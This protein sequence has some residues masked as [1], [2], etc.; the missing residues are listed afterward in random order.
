MSSEA[1][2][3]VV[4]RLIEEVVNT[5]DVERLG[6]FVS[7]DFHETNDPN[8]VGVISMRAHVLAVRQTYPDLHI[9]IEQQIAEGEWVAT[10]VTA[11][12]THL[13][14]WLVE[15][16]VRERRRGRCRASETAAVSGGTPR[17]RSS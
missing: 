15:R 5:G 16:V 1:S 3:L 4:R 8:T 11:S 12:G 10:R 9:T 13:G 17:G 2:K 7:P 14:W 6:E